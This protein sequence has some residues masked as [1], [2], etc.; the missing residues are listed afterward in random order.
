M[1]T[2]RRTFLKQVTL[3]SAATQAAAQTPAP[4]APRTPHPCRNCVSPRLHRT[5][6]HRHRLSAGRRLRRLHQPGRSRAASRLGDLQ[7][8][9][10]RQRT[11]LCLSRHLGA[12]RQPQARRARARIAHPTALRG[13]QRTWLEQRARAYSPGLGHLHRR[14]SAGAHR[15]LR[16]HPARQSLARSLLA[17]HPARARRVRLCPSPFLRYRVT[18][19]GAAP[20][21]VSIAWS[22]EN[23]TGHTQAKRHARQRIQD[24]RTAGRHSHDAIPTCRP[25]MRSRQLSALRAGF[26]GRPRHLPS[27]MGA[28][29][30]VELAH[31]LLGRLFR[32][33]RTWSRVEGPRPRGRALAGPHHRA[34]RARRLHLPAGLAFPQSHTAPLRMER[35]ARR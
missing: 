33:W 26:R 3:A 17:L 6:S 7:P 1:P 11:R 32:R 29:P 14:I 31:V 24:I 18:N 13:L 28:Q 10:Q 23:P 35:R 12:G 22:I 2:K 16:F 27:R 9:G 8:S 5:P 15:L 20:A 4:A 30:L 34:R 21:K 25:T 19:P